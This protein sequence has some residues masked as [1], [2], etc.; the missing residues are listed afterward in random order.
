MFPITITFVVVRFVLVLTDM[1]LPAPREYRVRVRAE[2]AVASIC[3][4]T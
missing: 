3:G 1:L 2:R 4:G